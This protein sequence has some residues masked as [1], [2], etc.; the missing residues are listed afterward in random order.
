MS[1]QSQLRV[2]LGEYDI[3][4]HDP[5]TSLDRASV[6]V[7]QSAAAGARLVVLPEMC[8]S[9][10]TMNV[11]DFAES[12]TGDRITR[13]SHMARSSG[14]WLVAG[15]PTID[16]DSSERIVRNSA[17]VFSPTGALAATYH[18]QKLFA[19]AEEQKS[20]T[21]GFK[22]VV[23]V[24]DGVRVAPFICYDLRFPEL[25]RAVAAQSDLILIIASWP[26]ARRTHWDVLLRARAIEN[27]CYVAGVNR[28]GV[29]GGI[30]Y[31]GGSAAFDPWGATVPETDVSGATGVRTVAVSAAE[32]TRVREA[33]PFLADASCS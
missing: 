32:V 13:L 30:P 15:V 11:A 7:T 24:I 33:Y 23:L 3:G 2:A 28:S 14:V 12:M 10:F 16:D 27:Q 8:T 19:Y 31:D 25:F 20:Y 26:A 29:G 22:P 6:V 5:E 1:E 18:K 17:L 4:W 21:R 9:G